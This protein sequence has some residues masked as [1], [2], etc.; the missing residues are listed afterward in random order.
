MLKQRR[1]WEFVRH[2]DSLI[3]AG[4]DPAIAEADLDADAVNVMTIHKAKGLE[5]PDRVLVI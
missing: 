5:F 3:E 4:D 1:V 2:L